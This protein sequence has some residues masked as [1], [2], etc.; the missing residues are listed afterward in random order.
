MFTFLKLLYFTHSFMKNDVEDH[1]MDLINF[2]WELGY[3]LKNS[4]D[5]GLSNYIHGFKSIP[6][7]PI[8]SF[9][10]IRSIIVLKR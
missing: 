7:G 9:S 3:N 1:H 2:H 10:G 8:W 6:R 4:E 5:I